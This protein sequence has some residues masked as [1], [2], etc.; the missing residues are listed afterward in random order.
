MK[1]R[2][3]NF[4]PS[5]KCARVSQLRSGAPKLMNQSTPNPPKL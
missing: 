3:F 4:K 1:L 5:L 2:Y